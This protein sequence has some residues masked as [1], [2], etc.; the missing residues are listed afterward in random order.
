MQLTN[1]NNSQWQNED[2]LVVAFLYINFCTKMKCTLLYM[3]FCT[4]MKFRPL[5]MVFGGTGAGQHYPVGYLSLLSPQARG[6]SVMSLMFQSVRKGICDEYMTIWGLRLRSSP[7]IFT[8]QGHINK[9]ILFQSV[10]NLFQLVKKKFNF[11]CNFFAF[12]SSK[13]FQFFCNFFQFFEKNLA[14]IY[15]SVFVLVSF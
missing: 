3:V 5:Y 10:C 9:V 12:F 11:F 14:S 2:S 1:F 7:A 8:G 6:A 4:K 13:K 15:L